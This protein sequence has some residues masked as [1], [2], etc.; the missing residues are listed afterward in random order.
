M[1][2]TIGDISGCHITRH[3]WLVSVWPLRLET[4]FALCRKSVV[5]GLL[6]S[7]AMQVLFRRMGR[8][9]YRAY[10]GALQ[11]FVMEFLLTDLV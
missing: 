3:D 4:G 6:A 7:L 5:R 11:S 9:H 2:Y 1:I 10:S 8:S